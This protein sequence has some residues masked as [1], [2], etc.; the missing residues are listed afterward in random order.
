MQIHI[1]YADHVAFLAAAASA[2][3]SNQITAQ[4]SFFFF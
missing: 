3:F 1:L 4:A 2:V